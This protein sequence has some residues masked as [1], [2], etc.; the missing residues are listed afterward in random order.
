MYVYIAMMRRSINFHFSRMK[1][2]YTFIATC[3][4]VHTP[5]LFVHALPGISVFISLFNKGLVERHV[6]RARTIRT[7]SLLP[8]TFNSIYRHNIYNIWV[9]AKRKVKKKL[10]IHNY[11]MQINLFEHF[12]FSSYACVSWWEIFKKKR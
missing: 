4:S 11:N 7:I 6:Y 10:T 1:I 9:N 2:L 8:G 3:K 12:F 5:E